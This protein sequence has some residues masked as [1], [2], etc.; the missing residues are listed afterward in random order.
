MSARTCM[1]IAVCM[2]ACLSMTWPRFPQHASHACKKVQC[3]GRFP[4]A[5]PE[6]RQCRFPFILEPLSKA[7]TAT[8]C[9]NWSSW[10]QRLKRSRH[11]Q[12]GLSH[13]V[14]NLRVFCV[15]ST[16]GNPS[17]WQALLMVIASRH[18]ATCLT[19]CWASVMFFWHIAACGPWLRACETPA[20]TYDIVI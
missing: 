3:S 18:S 1:V 11:L 5:W 16:P 8:S 17:R 6:M 12:T 10:I 2:T 7:A 13:I 19:R 20:L 4:W 9:L 14:E 15:D